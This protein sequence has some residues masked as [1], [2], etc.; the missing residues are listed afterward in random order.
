MNESLQLKGFIFLFL[1][2]FTRRS[3]SLRKR[4]SRLPCAS[5]STIAWEESLSRRW[6]SPP[7]SV[8][9]TS[10][11]RATFF[12]CS[13][14]LMWCF[15]VFLLLSGF[16][17]LFISVTHP[18]CNLPPQFIILRRAFPK[19]G[20]LNPTTPKH[21]PTRTTHA[22]LAHPGP[23]LL[24]LITA[25][26]LPW[27]LLLLPWKSRTNP[28]VFYIS[29]DDWNS[30]EQFSLLIA[31]SG[32]IYSLLWRGMWNLGEKNV[33]KDRRR[34]CRSVNK[35]LSYFFIICEVRGNH[36]RDQNSCYTL[37]HVMSIFSVADHTKKGKK[38]HSL[39][40]HHMQYPNRR[41]C[42]FC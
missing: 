39:F 5:R 20:N 34:K 30:S 15:H 32:K 13:H 31:L 35:R 29:N 2:F 4:L 18:L 41:S 33:S 25:P 8:L 9:T 19:N 1:F 37:L 11:T 38:M 16:I 6:A 22:H 23:R 27:L 12:C 21:P 17:Y 7:R 26:T 28:D 42:R 36:K 40:I 14:P 10:G 3:W 24:L